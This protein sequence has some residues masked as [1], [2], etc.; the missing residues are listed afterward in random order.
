MSRIKDYYHEEIC[1]QAQEFDDGEYFQLLNEA[2][3]KEEVEKEREKI[4]KQYGN[5]VTAKVVFAD[6]KSKN[7]EN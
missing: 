4:N 6:W 2:Q 1:R 5:G 7:G 3:W